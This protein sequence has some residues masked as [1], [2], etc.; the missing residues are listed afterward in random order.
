MI[1]TGGHNDL[2]DADNL[3]DAENLAAEMPV[4][5]C[6]CCGEDMDGAHE[7]VSVSCNL[8]L[9]MLLSHFVP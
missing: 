1:C 7:V 9:V 8:S 2:M 6:H 5:K 4:G 3:L